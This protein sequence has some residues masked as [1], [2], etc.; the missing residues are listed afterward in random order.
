[1]W[2]EWLTTHDHDRPED[3]STPHYYIF[4]ARITKEAV[5]ISFPVTVAGVSSIYIFLINHL[6][7]RAMWLI[8]LCTENGLVN[9]HLL[10]NNIP[11]T[12]TCA[13][14]LDYVDNCNL[15]AIDLW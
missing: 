13:S 11:T 7:D 6:G 4:Y 8:L 12:K 15:T 10:K 14:F 1:M 3:A 9:L 2:W 5:S